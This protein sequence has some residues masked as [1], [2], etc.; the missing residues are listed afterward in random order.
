MSTLQNPLKTKAGGFLRSPFTIDDGCLPKLQM[1][2]N[3]STVASSSR[4]SKASVGPQHAVKQKTVSDRDGLSRAGQDG[5]RAWARAGV[6]AAQLSVKDRQAQSNVATTIYGPSG[7][8][9]AESSTAAEGEQPQHSSKGSSSSNSTED[10]LKTDAERHIRKVA[11]APIH[12]NNSRK[13]DRHG[14]SQDGG[15][16][17]V[18]HVSSSSGTGEQ[19]TASTVQRA[20]QQQQQQQPRA[21]SNTSPVAAAPLSRKQQMELERQKALFGNKKKK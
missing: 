5:S 6:G 7:P 2:S 17:S 12:G 18:S 9:A 19:Q 15:E 11:V 13:R 14:V 4:L 10:H 21:S 1:A 20:T 16:Q 8:A 3:T